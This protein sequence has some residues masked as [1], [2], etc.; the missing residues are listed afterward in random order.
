MFDDVICCF[1]KDLNIVPQILLR[2]K[3]DVYKQVLEKSLEKRKSNQGYIREL[4]LN[5]I[6]NRDITKTEQELLFKSSGIIA[7]RLLKKLTA[8]MDVLVQDMQTKNDSINNELD[9]IYSIL[10]TLFKKLD[11]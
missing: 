11:K 6:N 9:N 1:W 7:D 2:L 8:V 4:I 5:D 10:K 3:D